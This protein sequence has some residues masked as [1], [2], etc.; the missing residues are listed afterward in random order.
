MT[1]GKGSSIRD[2]DSRK[3]VMFRLYPFLLLVL[4][5]AGCDAPVESFAPNSVYSLTLARSRSLSADDATTDAAAV[6]SELFGTPDEPLWPA[7]LEPLGLIQV[8]RLVRAAG[9][10]SS[11][12]DGTHLGLYRE[13]CVTCHGLDGGGAGPAS[14]YQNPHPRNFRHGVFKWKSTER[15]AKPTRDDLLAV[16]KNGLPGSPMPSFSLIESAASEQEGGQPDHSDLEVLVDYVVY[17]SVRG[18]VER[19][20]MAAAIDELEYGDGPVPSEYRLAATGDTD[21]ADVVRQIVARVGQ[22]WHQADASVVDV[23]PATEGPSGSLAESI[24]RGEEIFHGKIANCQ[25]CHG[26]GGSGLAGDEALLDY[27]DWGKEYSTKLGL[28]P[29]D[30]D[31]MRPFRKAG[32]LPP[33]VASPRKLS[34]GV[35]RGGRDGEALYRRITQGIAGTPMPGVEVVDE[36]N[37]VGLTRDQV[38]DLV[39]YL[40]SFG[41]SDPERGT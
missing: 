24:A 27:D 14:L 41:S 25:G 33:R 12:K 22:D 32:A 16:L 20:L 11:E 7:Q 17:L 29:S 39:R 23:P 31:Q 26:P 8:D 13:H 18:E 36:E 30:R 19:R 1:P 21:G 38:W 2:C 9:P 34:D 3:R 37:G 4:I 10:V 35:Y 6:A 28:T 15:A 40:Q 5:L